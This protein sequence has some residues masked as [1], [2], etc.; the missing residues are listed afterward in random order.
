VLRNGKLSMPAHSS[1]VNLS[2]R[3][4]VP[5]WNPFR[6]GVHGRHLILRRFQLRGGNE[7]GKHHEPVRLP[8]PRGAA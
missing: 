2:R 1:T 4:S 7:A 6:G 3:S 8:L 5:L